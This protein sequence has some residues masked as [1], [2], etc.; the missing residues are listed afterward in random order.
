MRDRLKL[1][2]RFDAEALAADAAALEAWEAH[3]NTGTYAGDWS[4]VAL[5]S[6]GGRVSIAPD[7]HSQQ[8]FADTEM[9][10]RCPNVR[11]AMARFACDLNGVRFLRLG[12]GAEIREHR[13]YGLGLDDSGE[14]R[15]H[16]PVVT[17]P[18]V[19]FLLADRPVE[20]RPGECWYL[21]VNKH[22]AVYN[23]SA[24]PRIHLVLDAVANDWLYGLLHEAEAAVAAS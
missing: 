9:L 2:L 1:A 17:D 6:A 20:M 23:R 7:L 18:A 8:G 15:I 12:P 14:A 13:D 24:R 10:D 16:I 19:E 3:F 22:H 11:A 4:G 5:R 21:D